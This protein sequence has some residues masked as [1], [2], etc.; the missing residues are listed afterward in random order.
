MNAIVAGMHTIKS[1]E[2]WIENDKNENDFLKGVARGYSFRHHSETPIALDK[3]KV[4]KAARSFSV[5]LRTIAEHLKQN[6]N[7]VLYPLAHGRN[8]E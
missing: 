5:R 3:F 8:Y 4:L 1:K 6:P 7:A 2:K